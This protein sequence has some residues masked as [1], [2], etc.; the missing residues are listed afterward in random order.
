MIEH[1]ALER[2]FHDFVNVVRRT[3]DFIVAGFEIGA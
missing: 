1:L 2:R 3:L